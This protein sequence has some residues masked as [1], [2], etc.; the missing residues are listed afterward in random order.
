[1][2]GNLV[3]VQRNYMPVNSS[4]SAKHENLQTDARPA[5]SRTRTMASRPDKEQTSGAAKRSDPTKDLDLNVSSRSGKS[6]AE[7]SDLNRSSLMEEIRSF[8]KAM[9]SS[10]GGFFSAFKFKLG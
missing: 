1:M 6:K 4:A 2:Q 7:P 10:A 9:T 3:S 8:L 5:K